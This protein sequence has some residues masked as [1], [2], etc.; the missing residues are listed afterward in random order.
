[1]ALHQ[2]HEAAAPGSGGP[3]S[4]TDSAATLPLPL[5]ALLQPGSCLPSAPRERATFDQSG[6][7]RAGVWDGARTTS[8]SPPPDLAGGG[9]LEALLALATESS[10]AERAKF[11]SREGGERGGAPVGGRED[12][13]QG[14]FPEAERG[15]AEV[16]GPRNATPLPPAPSSAFNPPG[17]S[18]GGG[19]TKPRGSSEGARRRR[20]RARSGARM[21]RRSI[22]TRRA[23]G[24]SA[25]AGG[26][27]RMAPV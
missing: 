17:G 12:K 7:A 15:R 4:A 19:G 5:P 8:S 2:S 27:A 21:A 20:T 16:A 9:G 25:S 3:S 23:A 26:G 1:M 22:Q 13:V 14:N 10:F 11:F 18:Q 24:A 6:A